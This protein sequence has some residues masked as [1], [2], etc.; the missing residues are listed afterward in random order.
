MTGGNEYTR[1]LCSVCA[2]TGNQPEPHAHLVCH[3]CSG[4]RFI[5]ENSPPV[6]HV[7]PPPYIAVDEPPG[8]DL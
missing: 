3:S 4:M 8:R 2:G 6:L 1:V 7:V 5:F